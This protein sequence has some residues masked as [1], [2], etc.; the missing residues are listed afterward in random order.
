MPHP[1]RNISTTLLLLTATATA[2]CQG[3]TPPSSVA[4]T[5]TPAATL[6]EAT[7]EQKELALLAYAQLRQLEAIGTHCDWLGAV[8]LA[9]VTASQEERMAWITWQKLDTAK[10]A[11]DAIAL[12]DKTKN[13]DCK[14]AEGDQYRTGVGHGAW[15]MRSSWALRGQSMLPDSN[16]PSW[17]KGKSSI[18]GFRDSLE[19]AVAGL[20]KINA[21]SVESS[22]AMFL[23]ETESLLPVRCK[24]TDS[25][26]PV[27]TDDTGL[28]SY[29]EKV[30]ELTE[31]FA[32]T[33]SQTSDKTGQL[34]AEI[35]R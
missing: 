3:T 31:A 14:S 2:A 17:F 29:A 32:K 15:Q 5:S 7:A 35:A 33:L 6:P 25:D 26:C 30:I 27:M 24:S 1:I 12:I 28:R 19:Q 18:V 11:A 20:E 23:K 9:A 10:A 21:G 8:E 16:H 22:Q 34:P 4:T 13:I